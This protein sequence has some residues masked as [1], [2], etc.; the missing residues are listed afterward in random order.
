QLLTVIAK[1]NIRAGIGEDDVACCIGNQH[2][3]R[4]SF[5][6]GAE[7]LLGLGQDSGLLLLVL[8]A[9]AELDKDSHLGAKNLRNN[10]L[11]Q[12]INSPKIIAAEKMFLIAVG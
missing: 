10:R 12:K 3:I 8:Y 1:K 7:F 9:P 2:G 4:G 5:K 6:Q 11:K